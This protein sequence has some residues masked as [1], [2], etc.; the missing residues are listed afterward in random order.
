MFGRGKR[1]SSLGG[2]V[3]IP[4][5]FLST[6]HQGKWAHILKNDETK[7]HKYMFVDRNHMSKKYNTNVS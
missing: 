2:H 5:G 1:K 6:R 3:V 7:C 4:K